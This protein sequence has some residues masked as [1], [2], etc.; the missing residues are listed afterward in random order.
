VPLKK[1]VPPKK[2]LKQDKIH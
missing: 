1:I 2:S